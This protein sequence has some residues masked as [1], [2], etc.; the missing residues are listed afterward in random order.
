MSFSAEETLARLHTGVFLVARHEVLK[1]PNFQGTVIL[2]CAHERDG[3]YGLVL[4][5]VSH[6]PLDEVFESLPPEMRG[7]R[8]VHLGG[9]VEQDKIQILD[10]SDEPAPESQRII[11]GLT[12]GGHWNFA[13]QSDD[14]DP[15]DENPGKRFHRASETEYRVFLGYSGWGEG[16]LESEIEVG[17]WQVF[18]ADVIETLALTPD[19]LP[20]T[21]EQFARWAVAH[22]SKVRS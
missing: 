8:L 22:P 13:S 7:P 16:Q 6:M 4:N 15:L 12:M 5:R 9:P 2:L 19:R 18:S 1:D 14:E 17:A 20:A 21:E 3:D 11:P 10:W